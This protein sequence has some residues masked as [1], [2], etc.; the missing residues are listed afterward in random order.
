MEFKENEVKRFE[1]NAIR[2][3]DSAE[4]FEAK[5]THF[6]CDT[7]I[8]NTII[9]NSFTISVCLSNINEAFDTFKSLG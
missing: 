2:I 1:S 4:T 3:K 7:L 6:R 8:V 5:H 9:N